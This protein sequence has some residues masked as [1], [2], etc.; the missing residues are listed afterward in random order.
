MFK[1]P[2]IKDKGGIGLLSPKGFGGKMRRVGEKGEKD[3][4]TKREGSGGSGLDGKVF[5]WQNEKDRG[6]FFKMR[7][8]S[9]KMDGKPFL[10][11][12]SIEIR[13]L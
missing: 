1:Q 12:K 10:L 2:S 13:A 7:E 4:G 5:G 8:R 6:F 11:L 9:G 3:Q